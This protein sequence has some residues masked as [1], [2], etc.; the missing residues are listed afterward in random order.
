MTNTINKMAGRNGVERCGNTSKTRGKRTSGAK[1][2]MS[3]S[4]STVFT[5]PRVQVP[6]QSHGYL[7]HHRQSPSA[8]GGRGSPR[9]SGSERFAGAKWTEPPAPTA[10]PQPPVHWMKP[11][12][13]RGVVCRVSCDV[14]STVV[15]SQ[16]K[17]MLKG[18][19]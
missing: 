5:P 10:L 8:G 13:A 17:M 2:S 15:R 1:M 16:L 3:T 12:A 4:P 9:S 7:Y 6:Q 18:Q 14:D 19:A 11:E